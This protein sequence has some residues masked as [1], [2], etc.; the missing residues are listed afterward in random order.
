MPVIT[1]TSDYGLTD[2][3]LGALKGALLYEDEEAKLVDIVHTIEPGNYFEA[4]F[5]LRNCYQN[6]PKNTV[7]LVAFNELAG[8]GRLLAAEMDNRYFLM[9]DN[10]LLPMVN[11]DLKLTNVVAIDMRQE[12][13]LFPARDVLARAACHLTRGGK[14]SLLGREAGEIQTK[15]IMKPTIS[16]NQSQIIGAVVY[17]DN[18]GNLISNISK[19]KFM[20]IGRERDFEIMLPRN[21]RIKKLVDSYADVRSGDLVAFFNSQDLLEVAISDA[22]G[23]DFN[24]ANTLL[25]VSVQNP[26]TITFE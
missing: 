18:F 17:I 1:L 9:A 15:Q 5:I 13:T 7:H 4:A 21:K 14:L 23:K 12:K 8:S 20:E 25:G 11:P 19:K 16:P 26:I 24:G 22:R 10:G 6:F 3:Y 2:H